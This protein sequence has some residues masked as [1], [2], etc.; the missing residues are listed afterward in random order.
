MEEKAEVQ[1]TREPMTVA[2]V[3]AVAHGATVTLDEEVIELIIQSREVLDE[4]IERGDLIYGATTGLGHARNQRLA[5]EERDLIQP[6]YAEMHVGAMG[7]PLPTPRVRAAM[8]VRL[9]GFARGGAGISLPVA[10]AL[11]ALLNHGIHPLIPEHGSVGAGDLS[12]LAELARAL[13]GRGEVEMGGERLPAS[14]AL[15][16]VGL[17]PTRFQPKDA[18]TVF[19]SNAVSVGH[20]ALLVKRLHELIEMADL[21]AAM[22][23]EA[24]SANTSTIDPAVAGARAS[25]GQEVTSANLRAALAGSARTG[26]GPGV[27]VQDPL[28]FRV[29]PQIHG[30]M[31]DRID[32]FGDAVRSELNATADNPMVD[33]STRR[34]LS[35]G[36]FHPVNLALEAESI[37]VAMAHVGLLCD[38]RMGQLWDALVGSLLSE[39][40]EAQMAD[41][42]RGS[43]P[44]M[45]G[46][47]L[48]YP[49]AG[50]YTRLRHLANPITLDVPTLDLSVE[51]HAT[52]APE[53]L[54]LVEEAIDLV[55]DLLA[56]ELLLA[57][58]TLGRPLPL[59]AMGE[60]TRSL[61]EV[62]KATLDGLTLGTP[63]DT[64]HRLVRHTMKRRSALTRPD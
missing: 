45:A 22:S 31:R 11:T 3:D 43:R 58:P 19:S 42:A 49:A 57:I 60:G 30:A 17:K 25:N 55:E 23:M 8:V 32:G 16:R 38:R 64:V 59:G 63:P 4:A 24:I 2:E 7:D 36:N 21:V 34:V 44:E 51:D 14:E 46:L 18:L 27:S 12:Q 10:Q 15:E 50:C 52:N 62:V 41:I 39:T 6:A 29:V 56:V 33:L 54:Q 5:D 61:A 20:A 1:I 53:A 28:S 37:R 40:G 9:S 47:G 35:N 26:T 13:L 48:R